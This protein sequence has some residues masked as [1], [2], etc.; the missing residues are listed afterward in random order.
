MAHLG[1]SLSPVGT[2]LGTL[3]AREQPGAVSRSSLVLFDSLCSQVFTGLARM[4]PGRPCLCERGFGASHPLVRITGDPKTRAK[5]G[6]DA[7][8]CAFPTCPIAEA[9]TDPVCSTSSRGSCGEAAGTASASMET[10]SE[11]TGIQIPSVSQEPFPEGVR[12]RELGMQS[13]PACSEVLVGAKAETEIVGENHKDCGGKP[14]S[15]GGDR[16]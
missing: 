6:L 5:P 1:R 14:Q 2:S 3:M 15:G 12:W 8:A 7:S 4:S 9:L 11:L 10:Q 16:V 13:C